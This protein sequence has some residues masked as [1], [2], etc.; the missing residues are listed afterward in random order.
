MCGQHTIA[1]SSR[2][3]LP[4]I[5]PM[6]LQ[7]GGHY[8]MNVKRI[9]ILI[10]HCFFQIRKVHSPETIIKLSQHTTF[11]KHC[12]CRLIR[13]SHCAHRREDA[14]DIWYQDVYLLA[15][16]INLLTKVHSTCTTY[17]S[18]PAFEKSNRLL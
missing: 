9:E 15:C 16:L 4:A 14:P 6:Q 1:F 5:S 18:L 11:H 3:V 2:G 10:K 12:T 17:L 7:V 8:N 13:P